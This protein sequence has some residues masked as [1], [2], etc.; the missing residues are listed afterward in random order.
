MQHTVRPQPGQ[1]RVLYHR[2]KFCRWLYAL[3]CRRKKEGV[4]NCKTRWHMPLRHTVASCLPE[5]VKIAPMP[6]ALRLVLNE[7][8]CAS[9]P[10]LGAGIQG[11]GLPSGL[12]GRE[13]GTRY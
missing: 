3:M 1:R 2:G 11:Y 9:Q 8:K 7:G 5:M 13:A 4:W 6:L 12:R 10:L